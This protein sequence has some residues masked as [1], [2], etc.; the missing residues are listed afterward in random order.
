MKPILNI[1]GFT[2]QGVQKDSIASRTQ[3]CIGNVEKGGLFAKAT[4]YAMKK[5]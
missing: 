2:N 1:V 5:K 4:S 3:S